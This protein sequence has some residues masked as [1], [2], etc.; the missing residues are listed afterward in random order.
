MADLLRGPCRQQNPDGPA[1]LLILDDFEQLLEEAA[2]VR[3][4]AARHAGLIGI[5]L[6]AFEPTL[7]DSRLLITSRFPFRLEQAGRNL[8][9]GLECIELTSFDDTT[10]RKL[11]LRQQNAAQALGL[12]DLAA[13]EALLPRARAAARGNPGLLD[14]LIA[15]LLLNPAVPLSAAEAALMDMEAYSGE[16]QP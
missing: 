16:R 2:G 11:T 8:A 5:F 14:L 9:E 15:R 7:T 4:V 3:P 13:R 6:R 1:L 10:E 12:G